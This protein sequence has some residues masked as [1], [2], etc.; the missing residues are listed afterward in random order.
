MTIPPAHFEAIHRFLAEVGEA[1]LFDYYGA[2]PDAPDADLE[3]LIGA[4]RQWAQAQQTNPK[5][6]AEAVWLIRNQTAIRKAL[7]KERES[8]LKYCRT[9]TEN[10][11]LEFLSLFIRGVTVNGRFTVDAEQS[12]RRQAERLGIPDAVLEPHL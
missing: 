11:S 9:E 7:L 4:R 8:Y 3:A 2:P 12:V 5:F 1:S 10:K 6:R